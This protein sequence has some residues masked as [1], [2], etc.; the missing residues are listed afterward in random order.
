M[1]PGTH[2]LLSWS[3]TQSK[4]LHNEDFR[5]RCETRFWSISCLHHCLAVRHQPCDPGLC[6]LFGSLLF[7]S[8]CT[9]CISFVKAR[10]ARFVT[11]WCEWAQKEIK[12]ILGFVADTAEWSLI[13]KS[14]DDDWEELRLS[15]FCDA[16]FG[17]RCFGGY[18]VKLTGSR[19]SYFLIKWVVCKDLRAQV[20]RRQGPLN[21][22][23]QPK[24]CCESRGLW[25]HVFETNF[26]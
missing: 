12:H 9:R 2:L 22:D 6:E 18:K 13:M 17:T 1:K 15:T 26:L 5:R 19:G 23:E 16:S 25:M 14:A 3:S 4:R 11:R 21:G 8:R 20:R 7:L 24:R 10:L